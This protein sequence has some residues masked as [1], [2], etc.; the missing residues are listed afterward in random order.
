MSRLEVAPKAIEKAVAA[1]A[2]EG[3]KILGKHFLK[4][5]LSLF[6]IEPAT[7]AIGAIVEFLVS[8]ILDETLEIQR[9]LNLR[10]DAILLEPLGSSRKILTDVLQVNISDPET[11]QEVNRQLD[12]AYDNLTKSLTYA[13][14]VNSEVVLTIH[15]Y[16]AL[17]C[18]IKHG[19]REFAKL[20]ITELMK[21]AGELREKRT[22]LQS[23]ERELIKMAD[24]EH[25]RMERAADWW[26]LGPGVSTATRLAG[27]SARRSLMFRNE[28]DQ[29]KQ[30]YMKLESVPEQIEEFCKFLEVVSCDQSLIL[31]ISMPTQPL[32]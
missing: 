3:A 15:A 28:A 24:D 5:S 20:H 16:M 17:V 10:L 2:S 14:R 21:S 30:E 9:Q 6:L 19:G 31:H 26:D 23:R 27:I 22:E 25:Q 13:E 7:A 32:T 12:V 1:A 8:K 11:M 18:S 4:G 29:L